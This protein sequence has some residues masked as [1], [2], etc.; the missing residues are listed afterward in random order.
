[1]ETFFYDEF[2]AAH[3]GLYDR[4]IF[5]FASCKTLHGRLSTLPA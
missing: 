3:P 2:I 4:T 5:V 1:M